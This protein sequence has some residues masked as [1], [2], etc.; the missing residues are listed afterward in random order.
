MIDIG[1]S[2]LRP[3]RISLYLLVAPLYAAR[4]SLS[5]TDC[6]ERNALAKLID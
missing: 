3:L 1:R 4:Y 6:S 2:D 5:S